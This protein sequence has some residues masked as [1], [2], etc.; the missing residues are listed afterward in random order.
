LTLA[1]EQ[2]D[3]IRN[4]DYLALSRARGRLERRLR[5]P[6]PTRLHPSRRPPGQ[7]VFD[8]ASGETACKN[9][10]LALPGEC[11]RLTLWEV[12]QCRVAKAARSSR[13]AGIRLS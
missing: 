3:Q 4:G 10:H 13:A 12:G 2:N 11:A 1:V 6:G 9:I 8:V 5:E 7:C